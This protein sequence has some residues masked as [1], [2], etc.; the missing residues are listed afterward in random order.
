VDQCWVRWRPR[1][2]NDCSPPATTESAR[3]LHVRSEAPRHR[4]NGKDGRQAAR[5]APRTIRLRSHEET[6]ERR[7]GSAGA[8]HRRAITA[9][10]R[11]WRFTRQAKHALDGAIAP[12]LP[13]LGTGEEKQAERN[14]HDDER[15]ALAGTNEVGAR[16]RSPVL[17]GSVRTAFGLSLG[18]SRHS[19]MPRTANRIGNLTPPITANSM[20]WRVH[21]RFDPMPNDI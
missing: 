2:T 21:R 12:S 10:S 4:L 3:R 11:R 6:A 19:A 5:G 7:R 20:R 13:P 15:Q 18:D 14:N 1:G 17:A 8:R 16:L 9:F